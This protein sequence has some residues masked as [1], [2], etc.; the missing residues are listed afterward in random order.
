MRQK[1]EKL[2]QIKGNFEEENVWQVQEDDEYNN[3][4]RNYSF[5]KFISEQ[6]NF[7]SS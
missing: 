4:T 2:Y 7:P 5:S 1:D 3:F 6:W